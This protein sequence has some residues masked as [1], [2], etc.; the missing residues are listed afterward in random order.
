MTLEQALELLKQMA[1]LANAPL[2]AHIQAQIAYEALL[3]SISL[4]GQ[5]SKI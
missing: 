2:Q 4:K 3:R 5:D 1:G